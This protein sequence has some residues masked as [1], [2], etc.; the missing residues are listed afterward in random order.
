[1][2]AHA[3]RTAPAGWTVKV[4]AVVS[5][6]D[7]MEVGPAFDRMGAAWTVCDN[8][9]VSLK[10]QSGLSAIESIFPES[11]AVMILGSDDFASPDYVKA[12][13]DI[14]DGGETEPFGQGHVWMLCAETG[15]IGFF[16]MQDK[17]RTIGAGRVFPHAALE[18]LDW[19]LW[20][21]AID[22]GLDNSSGARCENKGHPIKP[23]TLPGAVVDV[24]DTSQGNMHCWQKFMSWGRC[25]VSRFTKL[26]PQWEGKEFLRANALDVLVKE[27]S[28]A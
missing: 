20:T 2:V 24:K 16:E 17:R 5:P 26:M 9:P 15:E 7:A 6:E 25:P 18:A 13:T 27:S 1:M 14:L 10:W 3:Q 19:T 28:N 12:V 22:M 23:M 21:E 8:H 4:L 11:V